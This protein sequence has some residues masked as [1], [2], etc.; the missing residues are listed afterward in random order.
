MLAKW[1]F[2]TKKCLKTQKSTYLNSLFSGQS[3][4]SELTD[5]FIIQTDSAI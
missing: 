4:R 5:N 1:L 3:T 2:L